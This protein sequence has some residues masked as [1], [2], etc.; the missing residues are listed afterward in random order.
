MISGAL[1]FAGVVVI[2]ALV[3]LVGRYSSRQRLVR[4][5]QPLAV[6]EIVNGLPYSV[7]RSEAS[8]VLREIGKSFRLQPEILRLEDPI[9]ALTAIDS[10]MLG[11][12]QEGLERWLRDKGVI[13]LGSKPNTIRD[14]IVAALP[15]ST[16]SR[17]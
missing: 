13:S 10:W 3:C 16:H 8:E 14:L 4:G 17:G 11:R 7:S 1:V 9:A 15:F 6:A 12:G 5:R 2:A